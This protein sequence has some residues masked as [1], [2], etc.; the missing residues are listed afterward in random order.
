MD[1]LV[2]QFTNNLSPFST[3][4]YGTLSVKGKNTFKI[5]FPKFVLVLGAILKLHHP[6]LTYF[7][8][9]RDDVI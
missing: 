8:P 4:Q 3:V 6:I 9:L 2:P 7:G 1:V 5:M